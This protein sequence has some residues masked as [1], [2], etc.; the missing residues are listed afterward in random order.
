[1]CEWVYFIFRVRLL[2]P[3]G[4][5]RI[6]TSFN[7]SAT[8]RVYIANP[9]RANHPIGTWVSTVLEMCSMNIWLWAKTCACVM[10]ILS[11]IADAFHTARNFNNNTNQNI[12]SSTRQLCVE[13]TTH[14]HSVLVRYSTSMAIEGR[15]FSFSHFEANTFLHVFIVIYICIVGVGRRMVIV[16][17]MY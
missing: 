1:M 15:V 11:Y 12:L 17:V 3:P 13:L 16:I 4:H 6:E 14:T 8:Q 2:L 9:T 7:I 10:F 5:R